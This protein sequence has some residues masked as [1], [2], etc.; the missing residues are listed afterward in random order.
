LLPAN[1]HALIAAGYRR[2]G[3]WTLVKMSV[4][5]ETEILLS[6]RQTK[7]ALLE[8]INKADCSSANDAHTFVFC[9]L[10]I[11]HAQSDEWLRPSL[12]F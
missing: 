10:S 6:F 7:P 9:F 12:V 2:V 11:E 1:F 3:L 5:D 4:S 8:E